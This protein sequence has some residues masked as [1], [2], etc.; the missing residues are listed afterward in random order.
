MNCSK[1]KCTEKI[2]NCC[3]VTYSGGETQLTCYR[4]LNKNN[5]PK[6]SLEDVY[7]SCFHPYER[8]YIQDISN[9]EYWSSEQKKGYQ[10]DYIGFI[11]K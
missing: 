5:K 9:L 2:G 7:R 3:V 6:Q 11:F 4:D 8:K 10:I 1:K